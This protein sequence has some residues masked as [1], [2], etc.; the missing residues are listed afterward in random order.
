MFELNGQETR[1]LTVMHDG[2]ELIID[3]WDTISITDFEKVVLDAHKLYLD[4]KAPAA[5]TATATS[6]DTAINSNSESQV[7]A[8]AGNQPVA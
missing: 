7:T 6:S 4:L 8:A 3:V 5:A 1:S 2:V